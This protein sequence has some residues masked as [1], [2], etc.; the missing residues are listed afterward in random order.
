MPD[1]LQELESLLSAMPADEKAELDELL[2]KELNAI[3]LPNPGPQTEALHSQADILLYGGAAGGGKSALLVGCASLS[4]KRSLIV[5]RQSVELDGIEE[6]VTNTLPGHGKYVGGNQREFK[7]HDGRNIKLGGMKD[8]GSW[9]DYAGRA[10]DYMGFDEA[11][12]FTR[13]QVF[14]LIAWN[15]STDPKQ[16]CRVILASN[17][18]R[19]GEGD[20]LIEEFAPWLDDLFPNPAK[21]G[22]LRWAIVVKG[23]TEWVDGPGVHT[24]DGEE[25]TAR[26]RTFIPARLDDN[27]YLRDTGYRATLQS[28][29]EPLRSQLLHGDFTAGRVDHEWQV[30]PSE[31]VRAAQKRWTDAPE[32]RRRMIAL[33]AYPSGSRVHGGGATMSSSH[34]S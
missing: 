14:S 31:W 10:R 12:E 28:L 4:H 9:K 8:P 1:T 21:P 17:P 30:I 6:E 2:D 19:G 18:P 22:E 26:S 25:Y 16:R 29:P 27:P 34:P 7:F 11:G 15:R 23:V 33:S 20:W 13:E 5:R 3:W 32:K 24:I